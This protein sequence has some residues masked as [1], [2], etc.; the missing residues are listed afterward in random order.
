[1]SFLSVDRPDAVAAVDDAAS[2][3]SAAA[4]TAS[5]QPLLDTAAD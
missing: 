5:H 4:A 2:A 1:M 3:A